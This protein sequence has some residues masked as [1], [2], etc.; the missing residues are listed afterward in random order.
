AVIHRQRGLQ[1]CA[2]R[3]CCRLEPAAGAELDGLAVRAPNNTWRGPPRKGTLR[4]RARQLH[5]A[6]RCTF[7]LLLTCCVISASRPFAHDPST[8]PEAA[9]SR[10]GWTLILFRDECLAA[11]GARHHGLLRVT[12]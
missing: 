1:Y 3:L 10:S 12:V 9:H 4:T 6:K 8:W 2:R 7:A 5:L 11:D